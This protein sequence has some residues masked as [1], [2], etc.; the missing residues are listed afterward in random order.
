MK[1]LVLASRRRKPSFRFR[2]GQF[3]PALGREGIEVSSIFLSRRGVRFR[4]ILEHVDEADIVLLQKRLLRRSYLRKLRRR[5]RQL[6]YDVDDAVWS[7]DDGT[8]SIRLRRRFER[9]VRGADRVIAGNSYLAEVVAECGGK[10]VHLLP[11]VVDTDYYCPDECPQSPT[12]SSPIVLGWLGS[13]STNAHLRG[14]L[15]E[16]SRP[17]E[18]GTPYTFHAVSS[19]EDGFEVPSGVPFRYS[20]WSSNTEVAVLRSFHIGLMP[21]PETAWTVGKCGMKALL[22]MATGLPSVL[23]PVGVNS[24]IVVDGESGFLA[25]DPAAWRRVLSELAGDP[26]LR[27]R[28]GDAGRKRVIEHWSVQAVW[29]RMRAALGIGNAP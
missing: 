17:L 27:R 11:S 6:V 12:E 20:E 24:E 3:L 21:L 15:R 5:A 14:L 25:S 7:K 8:P 29:P 28:V 1:L 13:R 23:S 16:F 4:T 10:N 19:R 26:I 18:G 2:I 9:T 22:Y